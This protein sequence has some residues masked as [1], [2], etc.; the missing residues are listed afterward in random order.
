[1][2]RLAST[3]LAT[4][5]VFLV[6]LILSVCHILNPK[7]RLL[8][9]VYFFPFVF[10]LIIENVKVVLSGVTGKNSQSSEFLLVAKTCM[11]NRK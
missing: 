6:Y 1:M 3:T 5:L 4:L 2:T 7:R 10:E 11:R 9:I 8:L